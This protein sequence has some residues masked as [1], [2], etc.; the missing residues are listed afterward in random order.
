MDMN[1]K[2]L[3]FWLTSPPNT[4]PEFLT[5]KHT[6]NA[7]LCNLVI[8]IFPQQSWEELESSK[9]YIP[10]GSG[11]SLSNWSSVSVLPSRHRSCISRV[12]LCVNGL[13]RKASILESGV[14]QSKSKFE[15]RGDIFLRED[16]KFVPGWSDAKIKSKKLTASK[17][18]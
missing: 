14:T 8:R 15:T 11:R 7:G 12:I 10:K 5:V 13:N 18:L 3:A 4:E 16:N 9:M 1:S 6:A 2:R 17:C